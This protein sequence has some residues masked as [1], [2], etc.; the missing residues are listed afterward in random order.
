M[1]LRPTLAAYQEGLRRFYRA[2][3]HTKAAPR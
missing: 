3:G 2:G 1:A